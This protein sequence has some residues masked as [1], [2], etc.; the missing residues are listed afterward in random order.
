MIVELLDY[1]GEGQR[2]EFH[3]LKM[4]VKVLAF[5]GSEKYN[6]D[7]IFTIKAVENG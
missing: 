3:L 1:F 7:K 4:K 2:K 6:L 5:E